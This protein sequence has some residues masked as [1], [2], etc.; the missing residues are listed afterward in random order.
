M[1]CLLHGKET[2]ALWDTGAQVSIISRNWVRRNLPG[3][4]VRDISELLG[5]AELDLKTAN[6]TDLPCKGWVELEFSLAKGASEQNNIIVPFLAAKDSLDMPIVEFNVIEEITRNSVG[7]T[8]VGAEES[9]V[10]ML[11]SSLPDLKRGKVE[12]LV[13]FIKTENSTTLSAVESRKQDTVIPQGQ[14]VVV[15]CRATV[16]P[17][18]KVPVLFEF[19]ADPSCPTGL[20]IPETQLTVTGVSTCRVNIRVENPIKHDMTLR[21]RTVLGYLQQVKSVTPLEVKLK[22]TSPSTTVNFVEANIQEQS[23]YEVSCDSCQEWSKGE[24]ES[25]TSGN[26]YN[27]IPDV[28]IE[29]LSEEQ[30]TIV[31]EM[32]EEESESFS[33]TDDDV[34]AAEEL[35]VEINLTDSIPVQK[36]Y[37]SIPRPLYAEVK[38]YVEDLLN[39][40][41]IQKSRSAY[42]SPVVYVRKKD[43]TLRLCVDYR[44]LNLKTIRDSH[45]SPRVQDALERLDGNQWF[46]LL[47]QGK[48]YHHGFVSPESRHKTACHS[49]GVI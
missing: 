26:S 38:Q 34:G 24:V 27:H 22:E 37:T 49:L 3:Y 11:N 12:V 47:D 36:K 15:S 19:D 1:K 48:A 6:G 42:S 30:R 32:L 7:G 35:Q 20:E 25:N 39:R 33:I 17:V 2:E 31:R 4:D 14:S 44:Q 23:V 41:W 16:G 29:G 21:G 13:R 28:D 45:L 18:R 10:D 9:V 46:S 43:G 8:P 40:G 5:M